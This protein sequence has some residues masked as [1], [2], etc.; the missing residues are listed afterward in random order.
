MGAKGI[1]TAEE[2]HVVNIIPPLGSA[3]ATADSDVF[4]MRDYAHATIILA[5][6]TQAGSFTAKLYECDNFTPSNAVAIATRVYK[7]E[8]AA[9]D[10]LGAK[11]A[12]TAAAGVDTAAANNIMYVFE[13][14]ADELSDGYPCLQ[15]KL[16][17]LDNTTYLSAIAILSG[18]RYGSVESPTEIA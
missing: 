15:L 3:A 7:E 17:G 12:V 9:G 6:G 13:I 4:S 2:C 18:A 16:S 5:V 10:T 11:V 1:T 14:D 8:T